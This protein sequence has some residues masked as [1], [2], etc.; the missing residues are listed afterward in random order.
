MIASIAALPGPPLV[1]SG[2]AW[3]GDIKCLI[4]IRGGSN[5]G[6]MARLETVSYLGGRTISAAYGIAATKGLRTARVKK[7][8]SGTIIWSIYEVK[9]EDPQWSK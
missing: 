8:L 2:V 3:W 7:K 1:A 4:V 9:P 6:T 5:S